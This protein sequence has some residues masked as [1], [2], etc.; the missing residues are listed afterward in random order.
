MI[1]PEAGVAFV[2]LGMHCGPLCGQGWSYRLRRSGRVWRVI[3]AE[4]AWIS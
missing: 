2:H 4:F 1:V 3:G